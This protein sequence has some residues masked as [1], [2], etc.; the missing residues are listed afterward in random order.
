[1]GESA[2]GYLIGL[3]IYL[4]ACGLAGLYVSAQK[5]RGEGE[6]WWF[7]LLF[8]P[9]GLVVVAS[10]PDL[11]ERGEAAEPTAT[12]APRPVLTADQ[13]AEAERRAAAE[14][15]AARAAEQRR[16]AELRAWVKHREE[17]DAKERERKAAMARDR[18]EFEAKEREREDARARER[19]EARLQ[20]YR[21]RGIEPGSFAWFK[22][23]PELAQ[24]VI[25]GVA[26]AVPA[27]F[28][29]VTLV[30]GR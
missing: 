13:V 3:G 30:R 10:L 9:L 28:I 5:G 18:E 21:D 23:M 8:G 26:I 27:V 24:A 4:V 22:A 19:E 25:L 20:W 14:A 6:G 2:V 29:L 16:D 11:R 17:A 7:G 12:P 1:M 15:A